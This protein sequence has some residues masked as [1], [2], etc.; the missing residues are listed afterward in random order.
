MRGFRRSRRGV[1]T[2]FGPAEAGLVHA[3]V[4]DLLGL[5]EPSPGV[6]AG[7]VDL[8]PL[9]A[10]TGLG[11]GAAAA[12]PFEE[13]PDDPVLARLFPDAYR[14]D[15]HAAADPAVAEAAADFRRYTAGDLAAGKVAALRTVRDTL[16]A[17][18]GAV[19]LD[20]AAAQAWLTALTDLRLVLGTRI[21][22]TEELQERPPP[23]EDP[24]TP[25]LE[26]FDF[27]G[28]LQETLVHAVAGW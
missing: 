19:V 22:V 26:V 28:W 2:T 23:V 17:A 7:A 13:R 20:D 8:D 12:S 18:G 27:L 25:A 11:A 24:R 5:L 15:E 4:D 9:V 16:P 3:L 6:E 21:G 1:G 10:L 14:L